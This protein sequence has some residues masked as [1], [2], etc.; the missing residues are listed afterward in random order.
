MN[1]D[2]VSFWLRENKVSLRFKKVQL[3]LNSMSI[4][5]N[6]SININN[7]WFFW[8]GRIY[9]VFFDS[10]N[11]I[12][13]RLLVKQQTTFFNK[14]DNILAWKEDICSFALLMWKDGF[15]KNY[16]NYLRQQE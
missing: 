10:N 11:D 5:F 15:I 16:L 7:V 12:L 1:P 4:K 9:V 8:G 13:A 14:A 3:A 6:I 2:R